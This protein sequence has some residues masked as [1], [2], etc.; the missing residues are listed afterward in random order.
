MTIA[1]QAGAS[2]GFEPT[3]GDALLEATGLGWS[4]AEGRSGS[5]ADFDWAQSGAMWLSGEPD[6]PPRLA[7]APL[8]TR[9]AEGLD[10]LHR[11]APGGGFDRIDGAALLGE[12][13]AI[14]GFERQ[15]D[16]SPSGSCRLLRAS[17]GWL[18]LNLARP[19]DV[20]SLPAWLEAEWGDARDAW[21]LARRG[22]ALRTQADLLER[23]RLLS[24]PV[25]P[26]SR[27]N[28]PPINPDWPT[29]PSPWCRVV[30]CAVPGVRRSARRI[31]V[32]DLSSL[33]AGPLCSQLLAVAGAE[34]V[35]VESRKRPDGARSGPAAFFDLL[36]AGKRSVALD[37]DVPDG[38]R[39]LWGLLDS[40]DVVVESARPRALGQFGIDANDWVRSHPGAVWLSI[41][42]W[43]R[44]DGA[45][46]RVAF[47]DDAAVGAGLAVATGSEQRPLF[48]GDAI[49]DPLAG[50]HAAL[51]ILV[52]LELGG[53]H[54][55]D[56]ALRDGVADLLDGAGL[57]DEAGSLNEAGSVT[58]S[59]VEA[60]GEGWQVVHG[61]QRVP[62]LPPR[63]RVP[64]QAARPLGLDTG[65]VLE[66]LSKPC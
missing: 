51:A 53:G 56:V 7:P 20:A 65:T 64:S 11:L 63:T 44:E 15:G 45:L 46:P 27:V 57:F 12:R 40:A 17:D 29:S 62:V 52:S 4:E 36:N 43:G 23:A 28:P 54:L 37:F 66:S 38:V 59:R 34:V 19:D 5:G 33:W 58:K 30:R 16:V 14:F 32:V 24:L 8:A 10:R 25:A 61:N 9:A 49:A 50:I 42:G 6:A 2:R 31:R 13:A 39:A 18:A 3:T 41:T 26:A 60:S 55:L 22:V 35:K 48:C 21:E 1:P 47:G